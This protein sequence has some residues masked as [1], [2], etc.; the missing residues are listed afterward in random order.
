MPGFFIPYPVVTSGAT[1][2]VLWNLVIHIDEMPIPSIGTMTCPP[3]N[4]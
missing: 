4:I 3:K 1:K 2:L